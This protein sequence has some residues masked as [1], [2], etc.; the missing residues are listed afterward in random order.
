MERQSLKIDDGVD[1]GECVSEACAE[2]FKYSF[3]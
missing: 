2:L 1:T 3:S